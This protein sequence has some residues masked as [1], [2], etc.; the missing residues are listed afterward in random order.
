MM[1]PRAVSRTAASTVESSSTISANRWNVHLDSSVTGIDA[2]HAGVVVD[3]DDGTRVSGELLL[4]AT[5]RQPNTEDLGLEVA[6]IALRD[7]GHIVV[8][9]FGLGL[10]P[11]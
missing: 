5:G 2:S 8:D 10:P 1:L 3:L 6:R 9:E 11:V 4:V 7:D